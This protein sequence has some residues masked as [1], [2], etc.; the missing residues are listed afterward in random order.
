MGM[1]T[2]VT[3]GGINID[4]SWQANDGLVNVVSAK[5]P[6]GEEHEEYIQDSTKVKKGIWYVMPTRSGHHGTV[7]GM[8]GNTSEVRQFYSDLTSMIENLR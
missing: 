3:D 4:S 2:G 8:D 5:Y 1:Y 7:I 6:L